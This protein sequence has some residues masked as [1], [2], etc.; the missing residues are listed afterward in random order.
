M[1]TL[2]WKMT[3]S[4][5]ILSYLIFPC[6]LGG[7]MSWLNKSLIWNNSA[8]FQGPHT[9]M[10][11]QMLRPHLRVIFGQNSSFVQAQYWRARIECMIQAFRLGQCITALSSFLIKHGRNK[12]AFI[13]TIVIF[14]WVLCV[15]MCECDVVNFSFTDVCNRCLT[16]ILI[17]I[18]FLLL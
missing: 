8:T 14:V 16:K 10:V 17:I 6:F 4:V 11:Q 13:I 3:I 2:H 7:S 18:E 1:N 12:N 5:F 15:Y 9:G